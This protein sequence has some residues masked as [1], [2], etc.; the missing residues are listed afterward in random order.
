MDSR[1]HEALT[2]TALPCQG[3]KVLYLNQ[4]SNKIR[5]LIHN[6]IGTL[7]F[8]LDRLCYFVKNRIG[9]KRKLLLHQSE[10]L[11]VHSY[12]FFSNP[13]HVVVVGI[14]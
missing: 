12:V 4:C 2:K 10:T 1:F 14:Y 6:L 8:R 7:D 3:E 9:S 13:K 11:I 5:I